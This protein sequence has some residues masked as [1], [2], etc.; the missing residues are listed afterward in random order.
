MKLNQSR[1]LENDREIMISALEDYKKE[2]KLGLLFNGKSQYFIISKQI[3]LF[4][5]MLLLEKGIADNL[6]LRVLA[7]KINYT[8][9]YFRG[10][11]QKIEPFRF[12]LEQIFSICDFVDMSF[13]KIHLRVIKDLMAAKNEQ[14]NTYN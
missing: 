1:V 10:R 11:I 9:D 14:I 6:H 3:E 5:V 4:L 12:N 7:F 2:Y 13:R 8:S